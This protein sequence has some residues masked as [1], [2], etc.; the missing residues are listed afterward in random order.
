MGCPD[1]GKLVVLPGGT[2]T[3]GPWFVREPVVCAYCKS[4]L[5]LMENV[6]V[7]FLPLLLLLLVL[8]CLSI[9]AGKVI[10]SGYHA[11][12]VAA[13]IWSFGALF[14][15]GAGGIYKDAAQSY[16]D[17]QSGRLKPE[18]TKSSR[19]RFLLVVAVASIV[20]AT[21][22]ILVQVFA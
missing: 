9:G 3:L 11:N 14:V 16:F 13:S 22:G 4:N 21:A 12:W 20:F 1:C 8:T 5:V 18:Y 6:K 17:G 15:C 19:V 2:R 10:S 7:R